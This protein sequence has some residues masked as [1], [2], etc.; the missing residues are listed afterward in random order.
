MIS[1]K[2][3]EARDHDPR[4]MIVNSLIY[5][6]EPRRPIQLLHATALPIARWLNWLD[7]YEDAFL[8][9]DRLMNI[10]REFWGSEEAG[11]F[12]TYAGKAAAAKKIQDF[13]HVKESLIFCDLAWP[14]Y[15][16]RYF[17][18]SIGFST[19]ESLIVRAVT[20]RDLDEEGLNM[21]GERIF[22]L[23]R[24]ILLKQGWGGREGDD[25][26]EYVFEEPLDFLFFD[27]ECIAPGKN[28]QKISKKGAMVDREGFERLKDEY[29][30]L[31]GWDP[32]TGF[33][34]RQTLQGLDLE[35]IAGDLEKRGLVR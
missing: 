35:D 32:E 10:A 15:Q 5:A 16:V 26:L 19:M 17:D 23:Q 9:T 20:G 30:T 4:L 13:G 27:P 12:S 8:S 6:T 3:S 31:R 18:E 7:G 14:M 33:P 29:Y 24:S 2:A 21:I 22:N 25:L 28:G 1:T 11:D 34:I